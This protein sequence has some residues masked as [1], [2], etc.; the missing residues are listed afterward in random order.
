M[1]PA[2]RSASGARRLPPLERKVHSGSVKDSRCGSRKKRR[3][4]RRTPSITRGPPKAPGGTA[5]HPLEAGAKDFGCGSTGGAFLRDE[6]GFLPVAKLF[7]D[8]ELRSRWMVVL[9]SCHEAE[10]IALARRRDFSR[11]RVEE[12]PRPVYG[13]RRRRA[14]RSVRPAPAIR[15]GDGSGIGIPNGTSAPF[16]PAKS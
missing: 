12:I 8:R 7:Q 4:N 16:H 9:H 14:I 5:R 10:I 11:G 15:R 1:P 13:F 2:R 6:P 3:G